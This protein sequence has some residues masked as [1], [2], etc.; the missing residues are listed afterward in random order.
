MTRIALLAVALTACLAQDL[1]G[2]VVRVIDGDTIVVQLDGTREH[3]RYIGIDTPE[4]DDERPEIRRRAVAAKEANARLV[5]GRRVRLELDVERRD[6]YGRLLAYVWVGDTLVNE[7]LVRAGHAAPYTVPPNVK[8]ADRFLAAARGARRATPAGGDTGSLT[9]HQA[10]AHVGE[11]RTVCDRVSST[12]FLRSGR[13]P[14]FLNLGH[15]YPEQDLTVV[16]WGED[17]PLF[18]R[19]PEEQYR[20]RRICVTGRIELYR[21]QPQIVIR[22]RGDL[23]AVD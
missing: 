13:R 5:G 12:R 23:R 1:S 17:R 10:S 14:T 7:A 18:G 21:D 3:V 6:R 9:A 2:P 8:Y 19:A 15:P 4:M 22:E 11:V 16:I 20:N